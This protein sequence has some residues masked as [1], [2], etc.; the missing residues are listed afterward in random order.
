[1][2][3]TLQRLSLQNIK[4]NK[5]QT[6]FLFILIVLLTLFYMTYLLSSA[7]EYLAKKSYHEEIY[8]TWYVKAEV[9]LEEKDQLVDILECYQG[10][11]EYGFIYHQGYLD[12]YD[13][14]HVD[15]LLY[16]LCQLTLKEGEYPLSK[17][18][19]ALS[20]DVIQQ[21]NLHINDQLTLKINE[22]ETTYRIVGIIHNSQDIFPKIYTSITEGEETTII[23]DR[24]FG[25]NIG[26]DRIWI[27]VDDEL[28]FTYQ[29]EYNEYGYPQGMKIDYSVE[30]SQVLFLGEMICLVNFILMAFSSTSLKRRSKEFALLR[31]IGMTTKQLFIMVFYE[32]F[33]IFLIAIFI[34][35]MGS[36]AVSLGFS[37]YYAY[38]YGYYYYRIEIVRIILYLFIYILCLISFIMYPIYNSTK[39]AL[40]GAFDSHHFQ[41]IQIRYKKLK[42]QT[43]WRLALR[44]LKAYKRLAICMTLFTTVLS[45]TFL[46]NLLSIEKSSS[47]TESFIFHKFHYVDFDTDDN[48]ENV[49]YFENLDEKSHQYDYGLIENSILYNQEKISDVS[50]L[51]I[52]DLSLL[53][54]CE[55]KGK[56]PENPQEILVNNDFTLYKNISQDENNIELVPIKA[57]VIGDELIIHHKVYTIVGM[58]FPNESIQNESIHANFNLYFMPE[59]QL[60]MLPEAFDVVV[61]ECSSTYRFYFDEYT[62]M[63]LFIEKVRHDLDSVGC[64]ESVVIITTYSTDVFK[65]FQINPIMI[66]IPAIVGLIICFYFNH[67]QMINNYNDY[68]LYHML[69]M[70]KRD[71]LM[72]QLCKAMI[73]TLCIIVINIV[74]LFL[75]NVYVNQFIFP[76][77][78]LIV[79][80]SLIFIAYVMIY[81]VPLR[82]IFNN[83]MM[84]DIQE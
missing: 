2:N 59:T 43:K 84:L 60:Y 13:I 16:D 77:L 32:H 18:E 66:I 76:Y 75:F 49:D 14:G 7:N 64:S 78:Q 52:D 82:D 47:F 83:D 63:Q 51:K 58:I 79:C 15:S 56:I 10:D 4:K 55:I 20:E 26:E 29:A 36:L 39:N 22:E 38:L 19:I 54:N 45:M 1:M 80:W 8:G 24:L 3:K 68:V 17:D 41:Y 23:S 12:G 35:T 28:S 62:Q 30:S 37:Q 72:K 6:L 67:N 46:G 74:Y 11:M 57:A 5:K 53:E 31:G 61:E 81:C 44:E 65:D 50:T 27:R 70:T 21:E 73:M 34:G 71:I 25:P 9:P 48:E 40:S 33:Y 42:T 69:G